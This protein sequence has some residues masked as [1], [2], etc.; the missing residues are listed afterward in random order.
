MTRILAIAIG[1][2]VGW[3]IGFAVSL[4]TAFEYAPIIGAIIFAAAG[5][6]ESGASGFVYDRYDRRILNRA[7]DMSLVTAWGAYPALNRIK[8]IPHRYDNAIEEILTASFP[9][10]VRARMVNFNEVVDLIRESS[11]AGTEPTRALKRHNRAY[12]PGIFKK[13][14]AT[15]TVLD[16]VA[17]L[18]VYAGGDRDAAIWYFN[19]AKKLGVPYRNSASFL[20]TAI[21]Q[22]EQ[23]STM[24]PGYP[25]APN[26]LATISEGMTVPSELLPFIDSFVKKRSDVLDKM[27][28]SDSRAA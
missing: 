26:P 25:K 10:L 17:K 15:Y 14:S 27:F 8:D 11:E 22:Q 12:K 5:F 4:V 16:T 2:G 9:D 3:L 1:A 7:F 20:E 13:T 28:S 21:D 23:S 6:S 19:F 24:I 18:L